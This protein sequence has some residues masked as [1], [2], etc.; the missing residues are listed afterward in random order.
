MQYG[1]PLSCA[2]APAAPQLLASIRKCMDLASPARRTLSGGSQKDTPDVAARGLT[3]QAA[4]APSVH[5]LLACKMD[6]RG[7]DEKKRLNLVCSPK[8]WRWAG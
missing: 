5:A 2:R 3:A 1:H 6:Q 4:A 7:H 8:I